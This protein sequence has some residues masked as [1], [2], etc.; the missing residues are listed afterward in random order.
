MGA[1][2]PDCAATVCDVEREGQ[3][4]EAVLH[5]TVRGI[6]A[7]KLA[8]LLARDPQRAVAADNLGQPIVP[9]V[10]RYRKAIDLSLL[11]GVHAHQPLAAE[12]EAATLN[13]VPGS[14]AAER[15]ADA[16]ENA[17]I[18]RIDPHHRERVDAPDPKA[19][20]AGN[21][22]R[23]PLDLARRDLGDEM[24][25]GGIHDRDARRDRGERGST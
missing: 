23:R 20:V 3:I 6:D 1:S 5:M 17:P 14:V 19:A 21:H 10:L 8:G 15:R 2:D 4:P 22:L 18:A 16:S 11:H 9:R 24:A 25:A 13:E 12:P 7:Q